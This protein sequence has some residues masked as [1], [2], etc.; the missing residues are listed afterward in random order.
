M[1]LG[2]ETLRGLAALAVAFYHFPSESLLFIQNGHQAVYLFFSLSGFV[3]TLN[4]FKKMGAMISSGL[5]A[6]DPKSRNCLSKITGKFVQVI[7]SF[8]LLIR[9]AKQIKYMMLYLTI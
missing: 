8:I 3:I 4:Y 7:F 2:L 5:T 6:V 1:I 9:M